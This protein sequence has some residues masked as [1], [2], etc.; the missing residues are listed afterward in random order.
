MPF[1]FSRIFASKS[2]KVGMANKVSIMILEKFLI[3]KD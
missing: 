3:R 2:S 1:G